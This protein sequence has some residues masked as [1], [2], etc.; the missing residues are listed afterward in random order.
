[1]LV[2][3]KR[4]LKKDF[5]IYSLLQKGLLLGWKASGFWKIFHAKPQAG[6][7]M[8]HANKKLTIDKCG[9]FKLSNKSART[10]STD[11]TLIALV[12]FSSVILKYI[13]VT[14]YSGIFS[15]IVAYLEP[16]ATLA[17]SETCHIHNPGSFITQDILGTLP[18]HI[19]GISR[20]LCNASISRTLPYWEFGH[21]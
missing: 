20:T 7:S 3:S 12:N 14:P 11:I 17:Y 2:L 5:R 16:C 19:F 13:H 10:T 15:H 4:C 8:F 9:R 6:K 18:R 21:I 1:M